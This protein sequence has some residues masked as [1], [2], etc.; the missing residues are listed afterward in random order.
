MRRTSIGPQSTLDHGA[1]PTPAR[2]RSHRRPCCSKWHT[3]IACKAAGGGR[4]PACEFPRKEKGIQ[5]QNTSNREN[6]PRHLLAGPHKKRTPLAGRAPQDRESGFSPGRHRCTNPLL[7]FT[8]IGKRRLAFGVEPL[9]F[10]K[11]LLMPWRR[12]D[13]RTLPR[14]IR[15]ERFNQPQLFNF[16]QRLHVQFR[17]HDLTLSRPCPK[18]SPVENGDGYRVETARQENGAFKEASR[19]FNGHGLKFRRVLCTCYTKHTP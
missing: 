10:L 11:S 17:N 2:W 12:S 18:A 19:L 7:R 16:R 14:Q 13:F 5:F 1:N 9:G 15:P 8:P 6:N 3:G 4:R